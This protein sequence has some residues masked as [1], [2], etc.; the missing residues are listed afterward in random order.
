[1]ALAGT[2]AELLHVVP[3]P[4]K[5]A[6]DNNYLSIADNDFNFTIITFWAHHIFSKFPF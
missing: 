6:Y 1:M 5:L 2:G 3:R 4:N